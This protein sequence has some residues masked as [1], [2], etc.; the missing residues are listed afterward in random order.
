MLVYTISLV[1]SRHTP[2]RAFRLRRNWLRVANFILNIKVEKKGKPP[3]TPAIYVSNHRSFS[4][5]LVLLQHLNA[6]VIAKAEVS[7]Y[8]LINKG[9]ELT[10]IVY[11]KREDWG[12]RRA[13][14]DTMVETIRKGYNIL[15]YPEGT[16]GKDPHTLPFKRGTFKTAAN[17]SI[18]IVPVAIEYQ[19][20]RDLWVI[21][22]FMKQYLYQFSKW[23]TNVRLEF[24]PVMEGEDGMKLHDDAHQW[25]NEK[26]EMMQEGWSKSFLP[27][28]PAD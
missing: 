3:I 19:S 12:S 25:V 15:V 1:V 5:P 22:N 27:Q 13:T 2:N 24:G 18:P 21:P 4:D 17:E 28:P 11:V 6:Y 14:R 26:I 8:P 9:A 10:G 23:R 20:P 7:S 16:V